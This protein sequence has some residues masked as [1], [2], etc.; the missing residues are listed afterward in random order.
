MALFKDKLKQARETKGYSVKQLAM[1][2]NVSPKVLTHWE[3]GDSEPALPMIR[4]IC[5]SLDVTVRY[6]LD[7]ETEIAREF[8]E[9][10]DSVSQDRLNEFAKQ[11]EENAAR[12][13]K[14]LLSL[15]VIL[16]VFGLI[17]Q[18]FDWT[19]FAYVAALFAVV[20][21]TAGANNPLANSSALKITTVVHL[22]M[23]CSGV[24]TW[25]DESL[26]HS[27]IFAF[28]AGET[29]SKIAVY[30]GAYV[31][32]AATVNLIERLW[33]SHKGED[34]VIRD[35]FPLLISYGVVFVVL[36]CMCKLPLYVVG[37]KTSDTGALFSL[38]GVMATFC[39]MLFYIVS[40]L[41][42]DNFNKATEKVIL[43]VLFLL[44]FCT[45]APATAFVNTFFTVE[46]NAESAIVIARYIRIA[47][48]LGLSAFIIVKY[49]TMPTRPM[50][51][52]YMMVY[53]VGE[54]LIIIINFLRRET[55][56]FDNTYVVGALVSEGTA[57]LKL[58]ALLM[59][60]KIQRPYQLSAH[61]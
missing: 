3:N 38:T 51:T 50:Y 31:L 59:I 61:D 58:V 20:I 46:S 52:K 14:T 26:L 56:T 48:I 57:F 22:T 19:F 29:A 41:M 54:A 30:I 17:A 45:R 16:F 11:S 8:S 40:K 15:G 25:A 21:W 23:F 7:E 18:L 42:Y 53:L 35:F 9:S 39:T 28:P 12:Q 55:G 49:V 44:Y 1:L 36:F 13:Q 47:A 60:Y 43:V 4:R 27:N 24:F 32:G 2:L 10:I 33:T 6:L 5:V 34:L 37:F